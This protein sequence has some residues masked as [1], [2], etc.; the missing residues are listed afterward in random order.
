MRCKCWGILIRFVINMSVNNR[1]FVAAWEYPPIMSGES[2]VC[3]RTLKYSKFSFDVC[4]GPVAIKGDD[5]IRLFPQQGSKYFK[6]PFRVLH[7][8]RRLDK[9]E[10]YRIMMSR[11]M[12]PNGHLAGWLIK[13]IRPDIKWIVYFS[14]PIWNSPF[15]KFTL[16]KSNDH[17][18]NWLLMK[19]FGI[20]AKWAVRES[21]LLVF[22]N[23]RLARY[24]L[25]GEFDKYKDKVVV[26]PYGHEGVCLP[27]S[28]N[29]YSEKFSLTHVGQIYGNRT[30]ADLL[31]GVELLQQTAPELF[32]KLQIRQVGFV[33]Q[34]ER[35]RIE[36]S[37]AKQAFSLIDEVPYEYSL[38]EMYQA[39]CLLVIDPVFDCTEKNVYIPGKIYD[40]FSTGKPIMCIAKADSATGDVAR[41]A[42]L[43]WF[44]EPDG[45]AICT[46]LQRLIL[47]RPREASRDTYELFS[48]RK[49]VS[50]LDERIEGLMK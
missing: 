12:P 5:H 44:V 50:I 17:R 49:G 40:Y 11:V 43:R 9:E 15:L 26:A 36:L 1:I 47:Q 6:W 42:R 46:L 48:A 31:A 28:S 39:D 45:S 32:A 2:T 21:D 7:C 13:R 4:C 30:F 25:G 18:P 24:V 35:K 10:H 38:A 37:P 8:F 41:K 19:A 33:C 29:C 14:D 22:N 16:K 27:K 23:Q 34:S 20:P 3:R